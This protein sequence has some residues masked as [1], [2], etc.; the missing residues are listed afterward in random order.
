MSDS[1]LLNLILALKGG[2]V[3]V[4]DLTQTLS[5]DFPT[6]T[7]PPPLGR[8]APIHWLALVPA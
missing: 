7:L 1:T 8:C 2:R 4:L 3:R 5:P 6:I